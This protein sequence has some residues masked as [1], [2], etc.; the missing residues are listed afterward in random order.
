MG[1]RAGARTGQTVARSPS[2]SQMAL[3]DCLRDLHGHPERRGDVERAL[4]RTRHQTLPGLHQ[5][6]RNNA[7]RFA[8]GLSGLVRQRQRTGR[9]PRVINGILSPR[10]LAAAGPLAAL[11][12]SGF[13]R[14]ER[15]YSVHPF[16]EPAVGAASGAEILRFATAVCRDRRAVELAAPKT[17]RTWL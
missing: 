10:S 5:L 4:C 6:H 12:R 16:V 11:S 15:W 17:A 1:P 7:N 14:G 13:L 8:G 2:A 9:V 3:G